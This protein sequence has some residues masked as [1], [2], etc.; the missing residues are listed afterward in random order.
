MR[1]GWSDDAKGK[2]FSWAPPAWAVG[3][4]LPGSSRCLGHPLNPLSSAPAAPRVRRL[5]GWVLVQLHDAR[6]H[7][8][9]GPRALHS[10]QSSTVAGTHSTVGWGWGVRV[11]GIAG[12]DTERPERVCIYSH[13]PR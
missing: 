4:L 2:H 13:F 6:V 7:W 9:H 10:L 3:P 8:V 11:P 5:G 12:V 1:W